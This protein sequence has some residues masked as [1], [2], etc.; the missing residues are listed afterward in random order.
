MET[1]IS[2]GVGRVDQGG[3][4]GTL[5]RGITSH[6]MAV[7][8]LIDNAIAA[9]SAAIASGIHIEPI[10]IIIR[11]Q[12]EGDGATSLSIRD[13]S[14]GMTT[15]TVRQKL[16]DYARRNEE[17]VSLNEFGVGAKESLGYLA[18]EQGGFT[19]KTT[20]N[21]PVTKLRTVTSIEQTTLA[22]VYNDQ[23]G[24]EVRTREAE[25]GE[26]TGTMWTILSIKG[27]M[28]ALQQDVLFR[29]LGG[30]YRR[31]ISLGDVVIKGED[32]NGK[33]HVITYET[34]KLLKS[35]PMFGPVPDF[36][37]PE[38]LW[39]VN[40]SFDW[41]PPKNLD[42]PGGV[43]HIE[44]WIGC[45]ERMLKDQDGIA[46]IRRGR[47]VQMGGRAQWTPA[48]KIFKN[49]GSPLDKR[50]VGE[51]YCDQIPT[52]KIKSE[53]DLRISDPLALELRRQIDQLSP[54][55][56]KQADK[57]RD[58]AYGNAY[59]E[60]KHT[61]SGDSSNSAAPASA[62]GFTI[63]ERSADATN[64]M[65]SEDAFS[66]N[67]GTLTNPADSSTFSV[68]LIAASKGHGGSVDW[69][70]NSGFQEKVLS[71]VVSRLLLKAAV[72]DPDD[73][74]VWLAVRLIAAI[75][76]SARQGDEEAQTARSLLKLAENIVKER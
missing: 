27:G 6:T 32:S 39:K 67:Y 75:A 50:L 18:G 12:N 21:D 66:L 71:I 46:I 22:D 2:R 8:E 54:N 24:F 45:L 1:T 35:H 13:T 56:I 70:W 40:F 69:K 65:K 51:L 9:R 73:E 31:V 63:T 34:P 72:S 10:Q 23:I 25:P 61:S 3:I 76:L 48:P 30:M 20:W 41:E 68:Q 4:V 44:G 33:S 52:T 74:T 47:V 57:Y 17:T 49:T 60:W 29:Q 59:A 14:T 58:T 62:G 16:F 38:V 19:L 64:A 7:A 36:E 11:F 26:P 28:N 37:K 5:G 43:M 42:V 55:V 15:D 53:I